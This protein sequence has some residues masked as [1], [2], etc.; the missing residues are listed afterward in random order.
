MTHAFFEDIEINSNTQKPIKKPF[1]L[2]PLYWMAFILSCLW[3]WAALDYMLE[4]E[5]WSTRYRL[6]P[7]E[8]VGTVSSQILPIALIWF[9]VAWIEKKKQLEEETQTLRSYMNQLMYP[10]EEGAV[11]FF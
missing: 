10:T 8:F 11:C 6:A 1:Y 7:A 5:W 9:I 2:K 3:V 4:I